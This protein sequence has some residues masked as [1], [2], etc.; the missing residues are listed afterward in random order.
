MW[1][2][3]ELKLNVMK[4]VSLPSARDVFKRQILSGIG[5]QLPPES[6]YGDGEEVCPMPT[7]K[8]GQIH[9]AENEILDSLDSE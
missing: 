7:D 2:P 9:A 5:Q 1:C 6:A 4:P 8:L 3:K